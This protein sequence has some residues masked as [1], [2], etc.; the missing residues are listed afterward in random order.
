M[1]ARAD[2]IDRCKWL[3][4]NIGLKIGFFTLSSFS[5]DY[6]RS[7]RLAA[8]R[9]R[10]WFRVLDRVERGIVDLTIVFVEK[11]QS[12]VLVK[13]LVKILA[14]LRDA[15][16][17]AFTRHVEGYGYMKLRLVVEQVRGFGSEAVGWLMDFG[18]AE[19]F[20][21]NDYNSPV[22]WRCR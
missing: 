12:Q 7:V 5:G 16:K 17:S 11:V 2:Y 14:K 6:L 3:S 1:C 8:L 10:V 19:W 20:A 4:L 9:R 18:Y 22:G 13:E 21:V 15:S